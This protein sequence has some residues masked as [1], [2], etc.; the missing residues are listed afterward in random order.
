MPIVTT[1]Q[2]VEIS[3][4]TDVQ[5]TEI[6][7]DAPG[8]IRAIRIY[9]TPAGD[10]SPVILDLRIRSDTIAALSVTTPVLEF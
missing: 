10:K 9:G 7:E 4:V 3:D 1:M 5:V 8:F 6:V 2:T